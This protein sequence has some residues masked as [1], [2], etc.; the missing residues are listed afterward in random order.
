[1]TLRVHFTPLA[2]SDNN[3]LTKDQRPVDVHTSWRL[4]NRGLGRTTRLSQSVL[5]V[6][7]ME[8]I[9]YGTYACKAKNQHGETIVTT[10]IIAR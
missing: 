7:D 10:D 6:E 9:D 4:V 5:S 2:D 8:T 3:Y 1:M